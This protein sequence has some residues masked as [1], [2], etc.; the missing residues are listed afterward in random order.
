MNA[1]ISKQEVLLLALPLPQPFRLG[2]GVLHQ[3]PR[4]L[5]VLDVENEQGRIRRSVGEA[6]IDFPFSHYDAWDIVHV[7]YRAC[8]FGNIPCRT[9]RV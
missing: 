7:G 9:F 8:P 3:L 6:S 1:R 4:V 5:L 2:F